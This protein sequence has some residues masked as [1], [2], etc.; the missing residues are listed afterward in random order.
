MRG[1]RAF[2]SGALLESEFIHSEYQIRARFLGG[3]GFGW[4]EFQRSESSGLKSCQLGASLSPAPNTSSHGP[5]SEEE[6][7]TVRR[8]AMTYLTHA[9]PSP[10]V[11]RRGRARP[12]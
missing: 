7:A 12:V 1:G 10:G 4:G 2:E 3:T 6:P 11:L 8:P 9:N 5:P